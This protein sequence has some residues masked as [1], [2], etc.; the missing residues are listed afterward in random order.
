MQEKPSLYVIKPIEFCGCTRR[1]NKIEFGLSLGGIQFPDVGWG[2]ELRNFPLT[3]AQLS[4]ISPTPLDSLVPRQLGIG[5]LVFPMG[6]GRTFL[7]RSARPI[8]RG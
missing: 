7:N 1:Y 5:Q 8:A 3:H 2:S 6:P 4:D